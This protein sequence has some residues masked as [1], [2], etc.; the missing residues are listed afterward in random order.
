VQANYTLRPGNANPYQ[1]SYAKTRDKSVLVRKPC[2]SNPEFIAKCRAD[3]TVAA[4]QAMEYG[5]AL[6]YGAG[7][8]IKLHEN[9]CFCRYCMKNFRNL[10][11]EEYG[12]LR[13]LNAE[14]GTNHASFDTIIP[15]TLEEAHRDARYA[16]WMLWRRSMEASLVHF[17]KTMDVA[18]KSVDPLGAVHLSG[19]LGDSIHYGADYQA[20]SK[21]VDMKGYNEWW[22]V[23]ELLRSFQT[24]RNQPYAYSWGHIWL[25][26]IQGAYDGIGS[27][28]MSPV[29]LRPDHTLSASGLG[30]K[31]FLDEMV[32]PG[33]VRLL[34]HSRRD[35]TRVALHYSRLSRFAAKAMDPEKGEHPTWEHNVESWSIALNTLGLQSD[36]LSVH[37][38]EAGKLS[39]ETYDIFILPTSYAL[40]SSEVQT[41]KE[42]VRAG[43]VIIADG[44]VGE[45]NE[46]LIPN[47]PR[48]L[49][50]L[51]GVRPSAAPTSAETTL[52]PWGATVEIFDTGSSAAEQNSCSQSMN[53][54]RMW[55]RSARAR[56]S[57]SILKCGRT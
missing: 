49:D 3:F 9:L 27:M 10:L 26:V 48:P 50:G 37:E 57:I 18:I 28:A 56:P 33:L 29:E 54:W 34:K 42:Y 21:V 2:F 20:M 13:Q 43:G 19:T 16:S 39:S 1:E 46:H 25:D 11:R 55:T 31:K 8:E 35:N 38:L 7:D 6:N 52:S 51:F 23:G 24:T 32:R 53:R 22:L 40:S 15:S 41:I 45:F 12:N 4:T 14:W 5:G 36:M 44:R 17:Y 30:K 47:N